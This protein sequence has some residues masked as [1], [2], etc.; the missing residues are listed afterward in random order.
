MS[1]L[2]QLQI[3]DIIYSWIKNFFGKHYHR[4]V[5]AAELHTTTAGNRIFKYADDTYLVIPA[6]NSSSCLTEITYIEALAA[7]NKLQL[8]SAKSKEIIFSA[9]GKPGKTIHHYRV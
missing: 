1:N 8:N 6:T 5:N 4:I 9:R 7:S 3:P 2:A